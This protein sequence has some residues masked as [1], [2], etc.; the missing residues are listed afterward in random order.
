MLRAL[1]CSS[2][3]VKRPAAAVQ[4]ATSPVNINNASGHLREAS[5]KKSMGA[6][7]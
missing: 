2:V 7:S 1:G 4:A 3:M 6:P 5:G